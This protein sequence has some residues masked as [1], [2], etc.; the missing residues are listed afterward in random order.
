MHNAIYKD[1]TDKT[2]KLVDLSET[3]PR[4]NPLLLPDVIDAPLTQK[5]RDQCTE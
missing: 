5:G 2:G 4:K 1:W 3:N